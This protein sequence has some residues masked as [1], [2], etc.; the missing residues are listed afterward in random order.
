MKTTVKNMAYED[1]MALPRPKH[2][3]PLKPNLFWR[4]L[5]RILCVFGMMGTK[6][7]YEKVNRCAC[8]YHADALLVYKRTANYIYFCD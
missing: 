8:V 4:C 2:K 6:F 1:V 7:K 5:I 3:H